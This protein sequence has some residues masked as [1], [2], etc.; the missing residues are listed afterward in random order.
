[1]SKSEKCRQRAN[2]CREFAISAE[3][4]EVKQ[5]YLAM[6]HSWDRLAE[7]IERI[8]FV[9]GGVPWTFSGRLGISQ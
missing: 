3:A 5:T 2:R 1:M 8:P 6:A 9:S 7:E 4:Q